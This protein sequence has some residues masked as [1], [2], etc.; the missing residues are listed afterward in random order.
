MKMQFSEPE[1]QISRGSSE[2]KLSILEKNNEINH[3]QSDT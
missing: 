1:I 3:T 2:R